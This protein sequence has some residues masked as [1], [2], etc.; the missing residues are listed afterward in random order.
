MNHLTKGRLNILILACS[1]YGCGVANMHGQTPE[2]VVFGMLC[3]AAV[4][5]MDKETKHE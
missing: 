1:F 3:V 5:A 4:F 2:S